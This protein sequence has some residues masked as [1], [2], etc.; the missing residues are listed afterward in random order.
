VTSHA[1]VSV[2]DYEKFRGLSCTQVVSSG[3]PDTN[4]PWTF[5]VSIDGNTGFRWPPVKGATYTA[6]E[7]CT[8]DAGT[9]KASSAPFTV[10]A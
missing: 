1:A 6:E 4:A 9:F 5:H 7:T 2:A 10:P 3:V 8:G